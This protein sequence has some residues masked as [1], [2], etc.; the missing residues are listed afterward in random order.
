MEAQVKKGVPEFDDLMQEALEA[1]LQRGEVGIQVAGYVN[2]T[3]AFNVG[4]GLSDPGD[5]I[6]VTPTTLFWPFSVTKAIT[7]ITLHSQAA[8]GR[9]VYNDTVATYWPEFAH[10]NK[11]GITV[12]DVLSHRAGIPRM[13]EGVTPEKQADW[14][15]MINKIEN[16]QPVYP[17]NTV[18][19]YHSLTWG[20][21]VGELVSRVDPASRDFPTVFREDIL[22][23]LDVEDLYFGLPSTEWSR[24][25]RLTGGEP[26]PA[27]SANFMKA[28][29]A[30][31]FPSARIYNEP[32]ALKT[33]NPSTGS[34]GTAEAYA[35]VFSVL[36]NRGKANGSRL[37]PPDLVERFLEPRDHSEEPDVS[38]GRPVL[39]GAYGFWLA[40]QGEK[41]HPLLGDSTSI[42]LHPGAGD[43]LAWAELDTGLSVAI[44]HN[45]MRSGAPPNPEDH[46]Y[47]RIIHTART[48]RDKMS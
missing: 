28:M 43:S 30:E 34:I 47:K 17:T 40:G 46:P 32:V 7:A 42:L 25:A 48:I 12:R 33:V 18:N 9:V 20:W 35:R 36:A 14:S 11:A 41:A 22:G 10:N 26:S 3:L 2:D 1:S 13:P 23:P 19:S 15:W 6:P 45:A 4:A 29:P 38:M 39:V 21:I 27:A 8:K 44:C 24:V 31:V 37:L 5:D 16:F